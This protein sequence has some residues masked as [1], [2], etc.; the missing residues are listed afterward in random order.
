MSPSL[1]GGALFV[2]VLATAIATA[3]FRDV[4]AA[5]IVFGAYSLGMALFY[6]ILLAPDVAMTEAAI[7]AGVTTLLLLLTIAK[8]VRPGGERTVVHLHPRG[9]VV[10][11]LFTAVLVRTITSFPGLAA[12]GDPD[13]PVLSGE[14][15]RYYIAQGYTETGVENLVTAVLA[16]YRGFDTFGEAV[17]VFAA[18]VATLV[19]LQTEVFTRE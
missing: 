15:S 1:V 2:F 3:I 6:T 14:V 17:V 4:L 5:I 8:T 12:R 9:L 16:G 13:T 11:G 19:A 7:G 10:V 18:G